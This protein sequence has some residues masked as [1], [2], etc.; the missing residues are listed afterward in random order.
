MQAMETQQR[1][2]AA[3]RSGPAFLRF[4]WLFIAALHWPAPVQAVEPALALSDLRVTTWGRAEGAPAG[5]TTMAQTQ[6]GFLWIAA[7]NGLTRFDGVNF[8]LIERNAGHQLPKGPLTD[9]DAAPDGGLWLVYPGQQ[10]VHLHGMRASLAP[11]LALDGGRLQSLRVSPQG[12][13]W[14]SFERG[15]IHELRDGQWRRYAQGDGLRGTR[16]HDLAFAADGAVWVLTDAG[17]FLRRRESDAF[18]QVSDKSLPFPSGVVAAAGGGAWTWT[19]VGS[20]N[21]CRLRPPSPPAC[22]RA[23]QMAAAQLDRHGSMWWFS[24]G[25]LARLRSPESLNVADAGDVERRVERHAD[26]LDAFV[27]GRNGQVWGK[28][29]EG[30]VQLRPVAMQQ[31]R[32]PRGGLAAID[33][34]TLYV[35]SYSRGLMRMGP[36]P[37]EVALF[38]GQDDT[39]WTR[40]AMADNKSIERL[41]Q[42]KPFEGPRSAGEAAV[43]QR[44]AEVE[45]HAVRVDRDPMGAIYVGTRSPAR[46]WRVQA[47]QIKELGLPPLEANAFVRGLQMDSRG[48]L[49]LAVSQ[50]N[51]GLYRLDGQDWQPFGAASGVPTN[52]VNGI[53][54]DGRDRVW[55]VYGNG[56]VGVLEQG[57]WRG[58][59][60]KDGV[61]LGPLLAVQARG[62]Q[63]WLLGNLGVAGLFGDSFRPLVGLDGN[64]F[65]GCTGAVQAD[66]G[67]LWLSCAEGVFRVAA[68][69][70]RPL[71][72]D[73]RH[74][75]AYT[76]FDDFDGIKGSPTRG[77]P[78][79]S[80][81]QAGGQG[82][83]WFTTSNGLH[84]L[85]PGSLKPPWPAPPVVIRSVTADEVQYLPEPGLQLPVGTQ[86]VQVALMAP[87]AEVPQRT[88]FRY[89]LQG[90]DEHWID[91]GLRR[92]ISYQRLDPGQHRLEVVAA[93]REG[94][95]GQA[96]TAL[97]FYL[98]PAYYQ[99]AWFRGLVVLA[100]LGLLALSYL[101]RVRM[102]AARFRSEMLARVQERTRISRD[103][104]DTLL[105]S[106]Q[107]LVL[108]VGALAQKTPADDP[109]RGRVES[110]LERAEDAIREGRER[111]TL[112][113]D[114][115]ALTTDL[116]E[117]LQRH[118]M[119]LAAQQG[120]AFEL[121][122]PSTP[123]PL[124]QQTCDEVLGIGREAL[125][126]AMLH[127]EARRVTLELQYGDAA[128][129]LR[130][131]D[132]GRGLPEAVNEAGERGEREGHW[133]LRGMRE[134]AALIHA[135]LH[136]QSPPQGGTL[137]E[138]QVPAHSA[139][140]PETGTA[141]HIGKQALR[142]LAQRAPRL[143]AGG[144]A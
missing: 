58:Y 86:R 16:F 24:P 95:W 115:Q 11:K 17:V 127:A 57:R 129:S 132:D 70:W 63:V 47:G 55:A 28:A 116:V 29:R 4:V 136:I 85:D 50:S 42:F 6:D 104:H 131:Q 103:L 46:V 139:Y 52:S 96:V 66:A 88:R 51:V 111:I 61:A 92:E 117:C 33:D 72:G 43:L 21:L 110:A 84:W 60:A 35:A 140:E 107:G 94:R 64:S 126:N 123:R 32:L 82:R 36:A 44:F 19:S 102:L 45:G 118:A 128:L 144:P 1:P 121:L 26:P 22:W 125:T 141:R 69:A 93:D 59:D 56:G 12:R 99:T 25:G 65:L 112:L 114:P 119:A 74:R 14:L 137:V 120:V 100:A 31:A 138:L 81:A 9:M 78:L 23:A 8:D 30:L 89:R 54:I 3:P 76:R 133:G 49:W 67:D 124:Q 130:V 91:G 83:L 98:V 73:A 39:L 34:D 27:V 97:D 71:A 62:E 77:A 20:D 15:G 101:L 5:I 106:V 10:V 108:S 75:V 41:M 18:Q 113:R 134:R 7:A 38:S 90:V 105:Q 13:P 79:P 142:W 2:P 48:A 143:K 37:P 109:M 80:V 53:G 135:S 87:G 40:A 68:A 122:H